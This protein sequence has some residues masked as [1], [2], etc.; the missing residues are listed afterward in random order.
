LFVNIDEPIV[1]KTYQKEYQ[2]DNF[3]ACE[4]LTEK[5]RKQ[6]ETLII[7]IYDNQVNELEEAVEHLYK[8]KLSKDLGIDKKDNEAAFLLSKNITKSVAYF[9]EKRP[10]FAAEMHKRINDY[11]T[12]LNRLGLTD[13]DLNK[14]NKS[15]SLLGNSLKAFLTI[16]SGFPIYIYGLLNNYLPFEIPG[17]IAEKSIKQLEYRGPVAMV[18]G[19]F[20]FLLFY[21]FQ[22]FLVWKYTHNFILTFCYL[23]SLP[24]SGLFAYWYFHE[25]KRIKANWILLFIFYKKS[26]IISKLVTEREAIIEI[27]DKARAEYNAQI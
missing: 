23:I 17:I 13:K 26:T 25:M 9:I 15:K 22:I 12:N 1:A 21:S 19:T 14:E 27:F 2:N 20:T 7:S 24:L 16:I 3:T 6:L 8:N 18:T 5:I 4:M 10:A 11:L